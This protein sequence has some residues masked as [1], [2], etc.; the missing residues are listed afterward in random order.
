MPVRAVTFDVYS[1]LF[2]TPAGLAT[3]LSRLS[4]R[5]GAALD[6]LAVA[7]SWRRAHMDGLLIANSL[8]REDASNRRVIEAAARYALRN[9]DPPLSPQET[10]GLVDA[11]EHL[12]AWPESAEVLAAVRG[13]PVI[14]A[15]LSNGDRDMLE[16]LLAS[17]PVRFDRIISTEGGKF[18][19][20][21]SV[22]RKT[23]TALGV[24]ANELLHVAGSPTDA[25]GATAA[26]ITTIWINRTR[27]A[28]LDPRFAPAH[29]AA[30]LRGV[31]RY[32]EGTA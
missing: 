3:A 31:L 26:G 6:P 10:G 29:E 18:K 30:D 15:A 22:Y 19:P 12:P 5:R 13:R 8:D 14:L 27:D 9:L 32:L 16:A 24:P 23:L 17:L 20:H 2:D 7:R 28:V 1:A 25:V 4:E 11:W 21:P